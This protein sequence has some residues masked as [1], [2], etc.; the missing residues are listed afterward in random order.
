[1][2]T[3]PLS[4]I[5][6]VCM[7]AIDALEKDKTLIENIE[8]NTL[9]V[10]DL[11]GNIKDLLH[12]F[13]L[14]C[15]PSENLKYLFLGDYVDRGENS[16]ETFIYLLCMKIDN[17]NYVFLL[18]GNHEFKEVCSYYGLYDECIKKY[19]NVEGE[20][21]FKTI[22]SVFPFLP[23]AAVVQNRFFAV[24][25]G[26]SSHITSLN[27]IRK[28]NR[29]KVIDYHLSDVVAGLVWGDPRVLDDDRLT[30]NSSRGVGE[31]YSEKKVDEFLENN[32]LSLILRSHESCKN[33]YDVVFQD[34]KT[35]FPTCMTI[36][37]ASNYCQ[38]ENL[39]AVA[40]IYQSGSIA[41]EQHSYKDCIDEMPIE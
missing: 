27:D 12:I 7:K 9:V 6:A 23:L 18:R 15:D 8:G 22:T 21:V 5:R 2:S 34:S 16:I 37:S 28:I 20:D 32:K 17:P 24:H 25:G 35:N 31:E 19:G 36:F 41:I 1:M 13:S 11:H 38:Q 39:G 33:G 10:G 14:H 26:L 3:I 4:N 30:V 40:L 29:K